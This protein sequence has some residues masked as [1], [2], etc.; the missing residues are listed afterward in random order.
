M[1][2][3]PR[4]FQ[5]LVLPSLIRNVIEINS[6]YQC[7]YFVHFFDVT[8]EKE[9]RSE[10]GGTID[11]YEIYLLESAVLKEQMKQQEAITENW[12]IRQAQLTS[13]QEIERLKADQ[14]I[15]GLREELRVQRDQ[16]KRDVAAIK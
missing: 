16:G 3:L 4:A 15:K 8:S 7:D 12:R 2:G 6:V 14:V 9:S 5:S 11:P 1:Y 13:L 10:E